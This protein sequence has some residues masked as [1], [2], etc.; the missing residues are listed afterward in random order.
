MGLTPAQVEQ[1][2]VGARFICLTSDGKI[3]AQFNLK[4]LNMT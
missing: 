3:G 1:H 2:R 4:V